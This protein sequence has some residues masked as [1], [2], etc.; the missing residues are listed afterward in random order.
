V[1]TNIIELCRD[2]NLLGVDLSPAQETLLRGIY[3]LDPANSEQRD[4]WAE[5]A[6][7]PWPTRPFSSVSVLAGARSGKDSRI[8]APILIYEALMGGHQAAKGERLVLPCVAQNSRAALIAFGYI[9]DYLTQSPLLAG[10][11]EDVL[12]TELRLT[13]GVTIATFPCTL[14]SLRGWS[15]PAAVLDE[16]AFFRLEGQEDSD[17]E[18]Q[19]SVRR[20]M[21]AFPNPRL[22]KITTPY[23]KAGLVYED[24]RRSFGVEDP[25]LLVWVAP[26]VA[27]NPSLTDE[28]L[29]QERRLDPERFA[30][31]YEAVWQEDLAAFLPAAWVEDA[32]VV[33]RRELPAVEGVRYVAAV[34]PSGG[35]SDAFTLSVFHAAGSGGERRVVQDVLRGWR[36]SRSAVSN[37]EAVVAEAAALLK[38]YG[39]STVCG[40]RYSGQWVRQAFDRHGILYRD[41]E[42]ADGTYVDRSRAYL[43]AEPLF[44]QGRIELLDHPDQ[45]REFRSLEKRAR[46][47]GRVVVDHP[48]SGG[49]HDDYSNVAA[50]AAALVGAKR[51]PGRAIGISIGEPP[52]ERLSAL[53]ISGTLEELDKVYGNPLWVDPNN[54]S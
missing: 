6:L 4:I 16:V 45:T 34:D 8:A 30:R 23:L 43:E 21:L 52:T 51:E 2:P 38:S 11:V 22:V 33:G 50:V 26:S 10:Q 42:L 25:D 35:G 27:M 12:S 54:W 13:N 47:G 14:R 36:S 3:A 44:A 18:V 39:V 29:A 37:L 24:W 28:R 20:G 32:V 48:Q 17:V 1:D 9:R 19:T 40:D 46:Q 41:P 53:A 49:H 31:E 5:H 7:R 15:I